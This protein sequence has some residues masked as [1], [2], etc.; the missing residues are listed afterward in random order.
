MAEVLYKHTTPL[1]IL[2]DGRLICYQHGDIFILVNGQESQRFS[3]FKS[4]KEQ[5]LGR[6]KLIFRL[7]RLGIRA[8]EA[9][10]NSSIVL[11]VNNMLHE[12]NVSSGVLSKGYY[13]GE[14]IRPLVFTTVNNIE[15]IDD[16]I[17][18]GGYLG[19]VNKMP[20]NIY[21][22]TG[23]D[24]W[25]TVYT[26]S[27]GVIN[28]IHNIVPDPYRNCLWVF[29]GDFDEASAIWKVTDNFKKVERMVCNDQKYRGCVAFALP[30]GILYATDAPFAKNHIFLLKEGGIID[31]VEDIS[32]SCIYGCQWKD[33]YVFSSTVEPDGRDESL[34]KLIF[35]KK[36]GAGIEDDYV[37]LYVGDLANGFKE[38]YKERKDWLPFLFQ[39]GAFKFPTGVNNTDT[40]YFQPVATNKNDLRLM[41]LT[42]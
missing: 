13:C 8:V 38:V 27:D 18:F 39:F 30:E 6:S 15:G 42:F 7:L 34:K 4:F 5:T 12:L 14:G 17:Y 1:C 41:G 28:H 2:P 40:L 3:L 10:D 24:E 25:K 16:G 11:S 19:N 33:K 35:S 21:H 36:R 23:V 20:V 22:R 26:F 31:A 37:R 32:G 9:I 29:T